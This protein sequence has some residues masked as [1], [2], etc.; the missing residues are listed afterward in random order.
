MQITSEQRR[1]WKDTTANG[2]F[3][4]WLDPQVR[5]ATGSLDLD[6]LYAVAREHGVTDEYR[7]L[8][9]GQQRMNIGVRLRKV[10]AL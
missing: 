4:R 2:P 3:N 9:P 8:N 5:D 10:V 7:H 1:A 6:R